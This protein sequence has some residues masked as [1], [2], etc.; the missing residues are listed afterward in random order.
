MAAGDAL[1]E[2]QLAQQLIGVGRSM[3]GSSQEQEELLGQIQASSAAL[4]ALASL[5]QRSTVPS[6]AE[7]RGTRVVRV[8]ATEHPD[9]V[10]GC[11]ELPTEDWASNSGPGE[12]HATTKLHP[13]DAPAPDLSKPRSSRPQQSEPMTPLYHDEAD[14]R[15]AGVSEDAQMRGRQLK[16]PLAGTT[17]MRKAGASRAQAPGAPAGHQKTAD[18]GG[19]GPSE[20]E[21]EGMRRPEALDTKPTPENLHLVK[22]QAESA[23]QADQALPESTEKL[24]RAKDLAIQGV[25]PTRAPELQV[26]EAT[27]SG[28]AALGV[29]AGPEVGDTA[30]R[31]A[32]GEAELEEGGRDH[33]EPGSA[34]VDSTKAAAANS[35]RAG[36]NL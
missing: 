26:E 9:L 35:H 6:E 23:L 36:A 18:P 15:S 20:K 14:H 27:R 32:Q 1:G 28:G 5:N 21:K 2:A 16:Q 30:K 10:T 29:D 8:P 22:V 25:V 3:V 11:R 13:T 12:G 24:Q 19:S 17:A 7:G 31:T 33:G 4:R 34:N